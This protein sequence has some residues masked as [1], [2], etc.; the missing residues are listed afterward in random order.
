MFKTMHA[1]RESILES[2]DSIAYFMRGSVQY[3]YILFH[4][5]YYE[6]QMMSTFIQKRLESQQNSM[7]PVY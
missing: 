6:R 4:M 7:S 3:P 1:N 2:I 5:C